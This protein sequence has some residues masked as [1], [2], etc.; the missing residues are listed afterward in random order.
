MSCDTLKHIIGVSGKRNTP[1]PETV[2]VRKNDFALKTKTGF[3]FSAIANV[4]R[5]AQA[6]FGY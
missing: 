4:K 3:T 6:K 5:S 2:T 1:A